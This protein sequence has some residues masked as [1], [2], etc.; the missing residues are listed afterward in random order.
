MQPLFNFCAFL[1][2]VKIGAHR[3]CKCRATL[4]NVQI[5]FGVLTHIRSRDLFPGIEGEEKMRKWP[6]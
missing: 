1:E 2:I 4:L 5:A 6:K 3:Y